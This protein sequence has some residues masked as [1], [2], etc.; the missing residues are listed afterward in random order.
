M[1]TNLRHRKK[2][3]WRSSRAVVM[4]FAFTLLLSVFAWGLQYKLS[5]YK[6]TGQT[7]SSQP[8]AKLLSPKERSSAAAQPHL[9]PRSKLLPVTLISALSAEFPLCP[10]YT[11]TLAHSRQQ[12]RIKQFCR[13][14]QIYSKPPPTWL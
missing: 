3:S 11:S 14:A 2:T 9:I 5:L 6:E 1:K 7:R 4:V 8:A 10:V 12:R 13:T